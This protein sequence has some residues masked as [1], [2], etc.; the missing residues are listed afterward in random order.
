MFDEVSLEQFIPETTVKIEVFTATYDELYSDNFDNQVQSDDSISDEFNFFIK[1]PA[2]E[3]SKTRSKEKSKQIYECDHCG[4]TTT[5]KQALASHMIVHREKE[6][7]IREK[8]IINFRNMPIVPCNIC[9]KLIKQPSMLRHHRIVHKGI[10]R[11]KSKKPSQPHA[12]VLCHICGKSYTRKRNLMYHVKSHHLDDEGQTGPFQCK[13]CGKNYKRSS[14]LS[15]HL[16]EMHA[17]IDDLVEQSAR[18]MCDYCGIV[19]QNKE[20]LYHHLSNRHFPHLRSSIE[21]KIKCDVCD[22]KMISKNQLKHHINTVHNV[23]EFKCGQCDFVAHNKYLAIKHNYNVHRRDR[24]CE[25]CGHWFSVFDYV[26]HSQIRPHVFPYTCT[27]EGCQRPFA[28]K[29]ALGE[30]FIFESGSFKTTSDFNLI[31]CL[32]KMHMKDFS[33]IKY[34]LVVRFVRYVKDHFQLCRN[35]N[36]TL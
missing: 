2:I 18:V 29:N 26:Q 13:K 1:K 16:K 17:T 19:S 6:K 31:V 9:G 10:K 15:K 22:E 32:F 33:T 20:T 23:G 8:R 27:I 28:A 14:L 3:S 34:L 36:G 11:D 5:R 25:L 35:F 21:K 24:F 30:H 7:F 12:S 4:K